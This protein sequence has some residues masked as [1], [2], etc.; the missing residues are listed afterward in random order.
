MT[1]CGPEASSATGE[2]SKFCVILGAQRLGFSGK[3]DHRAGAQH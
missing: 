2:D 1:S 3:E